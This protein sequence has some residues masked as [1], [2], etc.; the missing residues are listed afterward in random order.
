MPSG[1]IFTSPIEDSVEG[2]IRFTY[3]AIHSGREVEGVELTFEHGKVVKATAKKN[4]AYLQ[5]ML[6]IDEGASVAGEFAIGTNK[7]IDRFTKN[8]LFD[9]KIGGTIHMAL[10]AGF[11]EIGGLNE[12]GLHWDMI[13]DMRNGGQIFVDGELFYEV[14]RVQGLTSSEWSHSEMDERISRLAQL[15]VGYCLKVQ[16]GDQVAITGSTL[17]APLMQEA[18]RHALRAGG[19]PT[20]L[21]QLPGAEYAF[22]QEASE[23]QLRYISPVARFVME[24]ADCWINLFGGANTRELAGVDPKRMALRSQAM[25]PI[26]DRY[27]ERYSAGE[28]RWVISIFPTASQAQEA[29]MALTEYE[30]FV[31]AA[32]FCDQPDPIAAWQEVHDFQQRL[33]DWLEGKHAVHAVGP[34]VD[35]KLSIEGRRFKNSDGDRNM[36]SGEIFTSP[37]ADSVQGWYRGSYPA[38]Y[39][40]KEV[41]G[42]ELHF[43][44][45]LIVRS[46]ADRNE[47]FLKEMLA[48]DDG[49]SRLGEFAIGTKS[50]HPALHP[51][52]PLR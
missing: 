35:L 3:P 39:R 52:Y 32:T 5:E 38:V 19:H 31:Y 49:A 6:K 18:A 42:I 47:D 20:L 21:P 50:W 22:W 10:G 2:T 28:M 14:G 34:N 4:E 29:E 23:D 51:E 33:V 48:I 45:G 27:R 9:E 1:E 41:L 43:E 36:P 44:D 46:S 25:R 12:S 16:P 17:T 26:A 24:E 37:V 13:C 7:R 11:K 15:L 8:I 40:G 30:D